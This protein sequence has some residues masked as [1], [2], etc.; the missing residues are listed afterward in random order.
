MRVDADLTAG[1]VRLTMGGEPTFV[2][3]DDMDGAEWNTA[4]LG[5]NKR[6]LACELLQRLKDRFAPGGVL[7]YG[8]GKWYPGE[9]LPRWALYCFWRQDGAPVWR[10]PALLAR[11]KQR[12]PLRHQA[13]VSVRPCASATPGR[14]C[15]ICAAWLRRALCT[16]CGKRARCLPIW[17]LCGISLDDPEERRRL[18]RIFDRGLG[19]VVGYAFPLKWQGEAQ[20]GGWRSSQWLFRREHMFLIPGDS[21][22]GYRLPLDSLPWVPLEARDLEPEQSPFAP[23]P[24]LKD[25]HGEVAARYAQFT[26]TVLAPHDGIREQ[27]L[28]PASPRGAD[29]SEAVRRVLCVESRDGRLYVFLPPVDGSSSIIS[30]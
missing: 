25:V 28:E 7:H 19:E 5:P 24:A 11:R 2:S 27:V 6:K 18:A 15:G 22:M 21:P 8:Q 13:C 1:D 12:I 9:S 16:I 17:T 10:E 23:R 30:I 20:E 29:S 4:A 26:P 14:A 3:I